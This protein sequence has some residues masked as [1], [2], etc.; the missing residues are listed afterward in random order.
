V[1]ND[2]VACA[3]SSKNISILS[4]GYTMATVDPYPRHGEGVDW[5][6]VGTNRLAP[7]WRECGSDEWNYQVK[8]LAE[9]VENRSRV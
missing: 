3:V 4:D 1:V 5:A 9:A 7:S 6:I 8:D 2:F